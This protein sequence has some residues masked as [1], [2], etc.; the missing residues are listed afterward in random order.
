MRTPR[1][2]AAGAMSAMALT[3][4]LVSGG[5]A[6]AFSF[7]TVSANPNSNLVNGQSITVTFSGFGSASQVYAGECSPVVNSSQRQDKDCDLSTIAGYPATGGAGQ[8]TMNVLAGSSYHDADGNQCDYAHG[9]EIV[10]SDTNTP[11]PNYAGAAQLS[12]KDTRAHSATSLKASKKK[13][14][15]G[16]KVTFT[17]TTTRSGAAALSGKVVFTDNGKKFATVNEKASGTV[18]AKEKL[19]KKGKHH[20]VA[21]YLGNSSFQPSHSKTVKVTVKK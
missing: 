5:P 17:A 2:V 8:F 12:F 9:C 3:S 14:K 16:K 19:K 6:Q 10:V 20:I 4:L 1:L 21:T 7:G 15:S 13:V 18:K 11:P